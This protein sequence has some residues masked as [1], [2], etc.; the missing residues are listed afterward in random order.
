MVR[1]VVPLFALIGGTQVLEKYSEIVFCNIGEGLDAHC[2]G[3][4]SFFNFP[5]LPHITQYP[6]AIFTWSILSETN[7]ILQSQK[8]TSPKYR[9]FKHNVQ[10]DFTLTSVLFFMQTYTWTNTQT[11]IIN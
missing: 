7:F 9:A 6:L 11:A 10:Y 3:T 1:K 2:G 8:L 5:K 4:W